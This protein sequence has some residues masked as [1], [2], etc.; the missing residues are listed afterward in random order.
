MRG[1]V[2]Y[3]MTPNMYRMAWC[4][5]GIK[6]KTHWGTISLAVP[7]EGRTNLVTSEVGICI[8]PKY[9]ITYKKYFLFKKTVT[10]ILTHLAEIL[11]LDARCEST[12]VRVYLIEFLNSNYK[13]T[14]VS[15]S[16]TTLNTLTYAAQQAQTF[17]L[18]Y[19]YSRDISRTFWRFI[20]NTF[21][22]VWALALHSRQGHLNTIIAIKGIYMYIRYRISTSSYYMIGH[23]RRSLE[24]FSSS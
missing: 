11:R 23:C 12:P 17:C 5:V 22:K 19:S 14:V 6:D 8:L 20:L 18:L 3:Y 15:V 21:L 7:S 1:S 9:G 24:L 10:S 13:L 4:E 16:L 2:K